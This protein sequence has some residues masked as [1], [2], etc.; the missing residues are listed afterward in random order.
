M[1]HK[2]FVSGKRV[3]VARL[4]ACAIV[5]LLLPGCRIPGLQSADPGPQLPNDFRGMS[6]PESSAQIGIVE[7]FDDNVLVPLLVQGLAQNQELKIRNQ[8]I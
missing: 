4:L 6:S 5:L 3:L 1:N 2:C 8:A 7:F